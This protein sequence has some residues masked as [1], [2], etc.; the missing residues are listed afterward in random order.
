MSKMP[1]YPADFDS[2]LQLAKHLRSPQGCPWDREQTLASICG[3]LEE[4]TQELLEAVNQTDADQI[5]EEIGDTLM[6]LA[7]LI[8]IAQEQ[9]LFNDKKVFASIINK[10]IT[11]H[12]WVFGDDDISDPDQALKQWKANK[13]KEKNG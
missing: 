1:S 3:C 4:E 7:L 13:K 12:T 6:N 9:K 2:L 11:R 8:C 10:I 5:C